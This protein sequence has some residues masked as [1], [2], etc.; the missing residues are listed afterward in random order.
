MGKTAA[1]AFTC[2]DFDEE[3]WCYTGGENGQIQVWADNCQVAKAIKAHAAGITGITATGGRLVSGGKDKRICIITAAGG[4]FTLEKFIDFSSSFP[5]AIDM[6]NGNLLVGLRNGSV[7]EFRDVL[8]TE[9]PTENTLI[10]SHFEGEVWGLE[11]VP[12]ESKVLT[13]G[14][15]NSIMVYD[16][17]THQWDRKGTVS[18]HKC[19]KKDKL[20]ANTASTMSIYPGNQ[21]ARAI[22]HSKKHGHVVVCSNLGKVSIREFDD[23]DKKVASLKEAKEWC[24]V[25]RYSPCE[26]F[27]ATG[28]HDNNIYVYRVSED[29]KYT[30]YKSFAKFSS[31]VTGFDWSQDST[32]IR[33]QDGAYEKLYFNVVD[34]TQD[35]AG[36][37]N[38]KDKEWATNTLKLGWDVQGVNPASEDGTH[39]NSCGSS[40]DKS[41]LVSTDDWGLVNVYNYPV[42][43]Y[44]H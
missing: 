38:T 40:E 7:I 16:Y 44:S 4:N 26:N 36:M 32:Y 30:L 43:D 35:Q 22:C 41:L 5:K 21:Q 29:G 42:C 27:L 39:I 9:N 28:S 2:L 11:L 23:L 31:Y 13:C 10:K 24:E 15:D 3:G 12:G 17:N 33:A 14:D 34:K 25:A 37:S 20:K 1:T 6:L 18:D 19:A 8:N